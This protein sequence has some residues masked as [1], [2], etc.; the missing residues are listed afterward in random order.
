M[1]VT[2]YIF[3]SIAC[4]CLIVWYFFAT[5]VSTV[6]RSV[7]CA[8]LFLT[9]LTL[10]FALYFSFKALYENKAELK[11]QNLETDVRLVVGLV[12]NGLA[13]FATWAFLASLINLDIVLVN[14]AGFGVRNTGTVI[15]LCVALDVIIWT[16]IDNFVLQKYTQYVLTPY[17]VLLVALIGILQR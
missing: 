8:L 9:T 13:E 16:I 4:L 5:I 6:G 2:L 7:S 15:L 17:L 14:D 10:F 12:Q 1:P 11:N 3:F